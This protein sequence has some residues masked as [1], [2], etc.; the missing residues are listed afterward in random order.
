[1]ESTTQETTVQGQDLFKHALRFGAIMGGISIVITLLIYAIDYTLMAGFSF[2]ILMLVYSLGMVIYGGINYRKEI[3][4]YLSYG[5][6]F[7]H[8]YVTM[9]VAGILG[10]VFS[11]LLY[12]VIDPDLPQ[13]LTDAIVANTE[14]MM[15]RFGAPEEAIETQLDELRRDTPARFSALGVLKQFGWGLLIY[16]VI[17]AITSLFVRR[18]PP[19]TM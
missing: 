5:K 14:S 9:L 6:A 3:G 11:I 4:G 13:N 7:Q 17:S 18:N 16:A 19:E 12:T 8:G 1:M 2:G 10:T 15:Q